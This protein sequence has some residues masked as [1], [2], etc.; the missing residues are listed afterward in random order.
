MALLNALASCRSLDSLSLDGNGLVRKLPYGIF[1]NAQMEEK[2]GEALARLLGRGGNSTSSSTGAARGASHSS[3]LSNLAAKYLPSTT[4]HTIPPIKE[5]FLSSTAVSCRSFG[6]D[7]ANNHHD[8]EICY[9]IRILQP[10]IEALAFNQYLTVLDVSGNKCGD[11]LAIA[12]G[13]ILPRNKT[14]RALFIDGNNTNVEGFVQLNQ[15]L[16]LNNT[17]VFVPMPIHDTRKI[18]EQRDPPRERLFG[19]LGKICKFFTS[20][21]NIHPNIERNAYYR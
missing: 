10:A 16:S 15:G 20:P 4:A 21:S 19:V 8:K 5:L 1:D 7:G 13:T 14:L 18:L 6:D 9:S 2:A 17:L 3:R 12:I 11:D